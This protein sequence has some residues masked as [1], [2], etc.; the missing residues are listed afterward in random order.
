MLLIE[1]DLKAPLF[2]ES[3]LQV[4]KEMADCLQQWQNTKAEATVWVVIY[5]FKNVHWLYYK[6]ELPINEYFKFHTQ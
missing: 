3:I 4:G 5:C 6:S 1:N 2:V